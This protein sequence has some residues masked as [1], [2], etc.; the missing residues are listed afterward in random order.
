MYIT[1]LLSNTIFSPSNKIHRE[2][3][4]GKDLSAPRLHKSRRSKKIFLGLHHPPFSILLQ[5]HISKLS[6]NTWKV[7]KCGAGEG[8]RRSVGPTM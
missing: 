2:V 4:R 1:R 3:G 8:W 6:K 7:L 5:H